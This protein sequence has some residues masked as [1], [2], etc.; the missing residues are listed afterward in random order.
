MVLKSRKFNIPTSCDEVKMELTQIMLGNN[1]EPMSCK[2]DTCVVICYWTGR[3]PK[4]LYKLLK[5]MRKFAAGA[6]FDV[7]IVCNGGDTKP[8]DIPEDYLG[9]NVRV[10]NRENQGWN[11]GAWDAG[12]RAAAPYKNFLFLQSE[13]FI[14]SEGWLSRFLHRFET[15]SGVGLLGEKIMW[16]KMTWNFIKSNTEIDFGKDSKAAKT[17]DQYRANLLNA[18]IEPGELGTHVISIILFTSRNILEK[19]N[20]FPLMG[21]SYVEAVSC[22]IA[23]SKRIQE[24]GFRISQLADDAFFK[25]G[26]IQFTEIDR[27]KQR[28]LKAASKYFSRITPRNLRQTAKKLLG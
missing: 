2:A 6:P 17:I 28:T 8:F 12:W 22:E 15:D 7:M 1:Y 5:G 24:M 10:I 4:P 18:D 13:C 26:H 3:S 19:I 16:D 25:I 23:F 21:E 11:L 14:K 27:R 9:L 20:G